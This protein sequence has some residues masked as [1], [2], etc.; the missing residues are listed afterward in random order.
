M[1]LTD[2]ET[3]DS[4]PSEWHRLAGNLGRDIALLVMVVTPALQLA[5]EV[6]GAGVLEAGLDGE[7]AGLQP[8]RHLR[9]PLVVVAPAE[10]AASM[11]QAAAVAAARGHCARA[12]CGL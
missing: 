12:C 6:D 5:V 4:L 3:F 1:T 8:G 9:L 2:A 11:R 7:C 10:H